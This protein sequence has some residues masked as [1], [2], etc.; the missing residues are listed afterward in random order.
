MSEVDQ[1]TVNKFHAA[2]EHEKKVLTRTEDIRKLMERPL[3][4]KVI[5]ESFCRDEV[6]AYT[7]MSVDPSLTPTQ[8]EDAQRMA[9]AGTLLKR[10]L[11][12]AMQMRETSQ[13]TLAD[14]EDNLRE[15]MIDPAEGE[16]HEQED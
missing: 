1:E 12:I 13:N 15:L 6:V 10:W 4:K 3:F 8:R 7:G 2:I 14:L 11:Q 16:A 5:L 9:Q